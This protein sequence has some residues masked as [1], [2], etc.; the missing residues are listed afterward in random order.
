MSSTRSHLKSHKRQATQAA[1]YAEAEF[2]AQYQSH[3]SL[4][5][6]NENR[7][8]HFSYFLNQTYWLTFRKTN[9]KWQSLNCRVN[10]T[11]AFCSLL[12]TRA[13]LAR[14]EDLCQ[15]QQRVPFDLLCCSIGLDLLGVS[16][17]FVLNPESQSC[18]RRESCSDGTSRTPLVDGWRVALLQAR[19]IHLKL[20]MESNGA[21]TC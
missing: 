17:D 19:S 16:I 20:R 10:H 2:E 1:Q 15:K 21:N 4:T 11:S 12:P 13:T 18:T 14:N 5:C 9:V 3:S 7:Q 8:R 6:S